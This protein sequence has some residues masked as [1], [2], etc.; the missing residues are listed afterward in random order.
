MEARQP[1][2]LESLQTLQTHAVAQGEQGD[3]GAKDGGRAVSRNR[4]PGVRLTGA[5]CGQLSFPL[6]SAR[7]FRLNLRA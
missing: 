5:A 4:V 6:D 2:R 7:G 3:D 1:V